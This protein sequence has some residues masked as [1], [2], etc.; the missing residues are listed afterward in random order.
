M[1][2]LDRILEL[3]ELDISIDRLE[4]R[5]REL[6]AGSDVEAARKLAD[7]AE[8]RVG[9]LRLALDSVAR[10]EKRLEGDVGSLGSRIEAEQKRLYDG[11]VANPKELSS[12]QAE[13][14]NLRARKARLEDE[15]LGQM[16]RREEMERRLPA[17]E[18]E[19]A[20]ARKRLEE[21]E[22]AAEREVGEIAGTIEQ[23]RAE[24]TEMAATFDGEL[25]DLYEDLRAQKK[26]VAAAAL[27]DGVCQGCHEKLS[28]MAL[29]KL[30]KTDGVRRCEYCRRILVLD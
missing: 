13:V 22:A 26:G 23:R 27:R 1:K 25:V 29:D 7:E 16:E 17:L 5:K 30:K 2:G 11:T 12:I 24:R 8:E 14:Q 9:E 10:E 19:L 15:E 18:E 4:S 6:E 3:Q 21:L 28:A 20:A